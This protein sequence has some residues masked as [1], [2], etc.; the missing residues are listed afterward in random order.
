MRLPDSVLLWSTREVECFAATEQP[1][2]RS[3]TDSSAT[4]SEEADQ[5]NRPSFNASEKFV[6]NL[7]IVTMY[8]SS[9]SPTLE[10]QLVISDYCFSLL[11]QYF[12]SIFP[13]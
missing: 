9:Q 10:A 8:P 3:R 11:S 4:A 5:S 13:N 12:N 6:G 1:G 7:I 2:L